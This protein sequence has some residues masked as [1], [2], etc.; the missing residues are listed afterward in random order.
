MYR[1]ADHT[2][3]LELQIEAESEADVF[4]DAL[5]ALAELLEEDSGEGAPA[6]HRVALSA[7]DRASLLVVWLEELVFL[8]EHAALVP[9]RA[10]GLEL[11]ADALRGEVVARPGRPAHLVKAV[12]YHGLAFEPDEDGWWGRIV[13]DV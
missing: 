13:L 5:V 1:W 2:A 6:E 3:E 11:T 4:A 12:T 8:A 7:A 10:Q 9:E